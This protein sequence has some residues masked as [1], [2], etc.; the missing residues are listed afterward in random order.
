MS[1]TLTFHRNAERPTL[2]LWLVD[3]NLTLIDFSVGYT[4]G[5]KIGA[6]GATALLNKTSG[7]TGAAGAG[8]EPVGTPNVTVAWAAGE[9]NITPGNYR[10]QLV[11][12]T[13]GLDRTFQGDITIL[14]VVN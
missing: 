1:A 5:F 7:I 11:A 6:V 8:T 4:F 2:K 10:W 9:L 13:G 3:D 12:T 14:D